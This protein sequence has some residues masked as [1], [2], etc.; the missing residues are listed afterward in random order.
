MLLS[1]V[2]CSCFLEKKDKEKYFKIDLK[3]ETTSC[4]CAGLCRFININMYYYS[5]YIYNETIQSIKNKND[6]ID[7]MELQMI[8]C[9][10]TKNTKGTQKK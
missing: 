3:W 7:G 5:I 8:C 6:E 10:L 9:R 1:M 2:V 4:I